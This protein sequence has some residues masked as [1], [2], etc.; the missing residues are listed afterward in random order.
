MEQPKLNINKGLRHE[1]VNFAVLVMA[2]K[3]EGKNLH[4]SFYYDYLHT[5]QP[6][7]HNQ[8]YLLL[9][10]VSCNEIGLKQTH[11]FAELRKY[12]E[13]LNRYYTGMLGKVFIVN[14]IENLNKY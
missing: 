3:I 5:M 14:S 13:P 1:N 2:I 12:T 11:L 7:K 6:I 9:L 8:N 10:F 4:Q